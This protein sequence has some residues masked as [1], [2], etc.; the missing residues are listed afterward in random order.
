[1]ELISEMNLT[2]QNEFKQMIELMANNPEDRIVEKL[3]TL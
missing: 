1:L 2:T 3:A